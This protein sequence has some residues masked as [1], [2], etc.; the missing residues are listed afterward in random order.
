MVFNIEKNL[1]KM[2]KQPELGKKVLVLR[3][4]KGLTQS[5]LA[6]ISNVSLRTIQRIESGEVTPR[7]YTI[8]VVFESLDYQSKTNISSINQNGF[9]Q[10]LNKLIDLFNLKTNT[11]QKLSVLSLVIMISVLGIFLKVNNV[12]AQ[13]IQD[14]HLAGSER[15][16]YDISLDKKVYKTKNGS[17]LLESK[18]KKVK[19]FGTLMQSCSATDFL[20]KRV[21]MTSYIK[22]E[23]VEDWTGMWLRIDSSDRKKSLGFDNMND[24]PIKGNTDWKK[25]EIILDVPQESATL[26][27]GVLLSGSGKVWFDDVKF[28]VVDNSVEQTKENGEL[29]KPSNLSFEN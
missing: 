14:W 26:N 6:E 4:G 9:H 15:E 21:K 13:K 2:M 27:Y 7:N 22:T 12:N 1:K 24:R 8:K 19:G 5:E 25:C 17:A 29:K 20:G 23:N 3:Q 10:F 16:S 28:T 18:E 11:M